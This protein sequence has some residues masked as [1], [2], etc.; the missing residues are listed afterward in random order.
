MKILSGTEIKALQAQGA[1]IVV[2]FYADWCGPC[3]MLTPIIEELAKDYEG[4]V[5]IVK[6]N[7]DNDGDFARQYGVMS[8][9]TIISFK[10]ETV[11]SQSVGYK[12]KAELDKLVQ[13]LL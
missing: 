6:L 5:E 2:D 8:I 12:P 11:V 1:L 7:V 4:K 13:G 10:G 9:P 3:K